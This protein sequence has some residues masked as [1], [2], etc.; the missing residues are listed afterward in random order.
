MSETP[1]TAAAAAPAP[2]GR[3]W[4]RGTLAGGL[5]LATLVLGAGAWLWHSGPMQARLL[6][7]VPGLSVEGFKG[8][9][10]GG[11]FAIEPVRW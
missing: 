3:R 1:Q 11:P 5:V 10:T 8:R 2:R 7:L 4:L 6:Q 9:A